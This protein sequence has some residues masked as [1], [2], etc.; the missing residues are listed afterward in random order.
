MCIRDSQQEDAGG[1]VG[2]EV[3]V[4]AGD[5]DRGAL[6]LADTLNHVGDS[7]LIE[8]NRHSQAGHCR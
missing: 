5:D 4:V 8:S 3:E 1:D 2:N 7:H 6:L